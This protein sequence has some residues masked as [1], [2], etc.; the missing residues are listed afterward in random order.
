MKPSTWRA[1]RRH[2]PRRLRAH[3]AGLTLEDRDYPEAAEYFR[4]AYDCYVAMELFNRSMAPLAGLARLAATCWRL[5]SGNAYLEQ[6]LDHLA[7]HELDKTE[8][9]FRVYVTCYRL[10]HAA[11]DPRAADFLTIAQEHLRIRAASLSETQ[12]LRMFWDMTDHREI[13]DTALPLR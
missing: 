6:M 13:R 1:V 11:G 2:A 7:A 9:G 4:Q 5:R 10:L 8:E 3:C 12:H